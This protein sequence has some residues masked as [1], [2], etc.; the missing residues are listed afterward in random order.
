MIVHGDVSSSG[1]DADL[2]GAAPMNGG[3][4]LGSF[5]MLGGDELPQG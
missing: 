5:E 1:N 4:D 3:P 2:F